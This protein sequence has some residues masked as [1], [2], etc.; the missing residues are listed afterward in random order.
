MRI[1]PDEEKTERRS[2]E[3]VRN[4]HDPILLFSSYH[5]CHSDSQKVWSMFCSL[6]GGRFVYRGFSPVPDL[7]R[8]VPGCEPVPVLTPILA[9][10]KSTIPS[11]SK[12]IAAPPSRS[13]LSNFHYAV[14]GLG[15]KGC[16][17][18][19]T[20]ATNSV[21]VP[22]AIRPHGPRF[23][24]AMSLLRSS[25]SSHMLASGRSSSTP[26]IPTCTAFNCSL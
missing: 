22:S 19:F 10:S 20:F 17:P 12:N 6:V 9:G 8:P 24:S 3:S 26:T 11:V 15:I 5:V 14:A 25:I 1:L 21:V 7:R 2:G 18:S 13:S 4:P 16:F 23:T